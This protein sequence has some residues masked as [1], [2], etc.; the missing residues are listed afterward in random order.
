MLNE[1]IKINEK[2]KSSFSLL[3]R[4]VSPLLRLFRHSKVKRVAQRQRKGRL[5][6]FIDFNIN[7]YLLHVKRE[8]YSVKLICRNL[9]ALF[10]H[11]KKAVSHVDV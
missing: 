4:C 1:D 8:F 2:R 6:F 5:S 9:H 10:S 3:L 11:V 7:I